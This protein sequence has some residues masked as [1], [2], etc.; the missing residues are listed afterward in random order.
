MSN[1]VPIQNVSPNDMP[2]IWRL[3]LRIADARELVKSHQLVCKTWKNIIS[4]RSFWILKSNEEGCRELL[5]PRDILAAYPDVNWDFPRIFIKQPFNRNL[6]KNCSG[7]HRKN[8]WLCHSY[9][10]AVLPEQPPEN[11]EEHDPLINTCFSFSLIPSVKTQIIN[12]RDYGFDNEFLS[13]FKPTIEISE[14]YA[15]PLHA[16]FLYTMKVEFVSSTDVDS[17]QNNLNEFKF[18]SEV[19]SVNPTEWCEVKNAFKNYRKDVEFIEFC[20]GSRSI[21]GGNGVCGPKTAEASVIFRY[22]DNAH[23]N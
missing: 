10:H 17:A 16:S 12:F 11:V 5:P 8:G 22:E 2:D 9:K 6:I 15:H 21:Y 18:R 13:K 23:F 7:K 20:S 1:D 14:M 3:I 4:A 19:P